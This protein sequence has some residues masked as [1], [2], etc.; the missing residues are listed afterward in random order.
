MIAAVCVFGTPFTGSS[1]LRFAY[2]TL[3]MTSLV[4]IG[5]AISSLCSTGQQAILGSVTL[6][7]SGLAA[8]VEN[9]P[10]MLQWAAAPIS[11]E[12]FPIILP[13]C[14][15]EAVPPEEV[16]RQAWTMAVTALATRSIF[17]RCVRSTPQ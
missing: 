2:L 4:G 7:V 16:F 5:L 13:G 17:K 11:L 8:P 10:E 14:F 12:H 3:F 1:S 6:A 9:M 15:L